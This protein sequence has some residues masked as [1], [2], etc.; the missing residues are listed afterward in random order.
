MRRKGSDF[1]SIRK[2]FSEILEILAQNALPPRRISDYPP[3]EKQGYI[4]IYSISV[5]HDRAQILDMLA[6]CKCCQHYQQKVG[7]NK[8]HK[9]I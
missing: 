4:T 1:F 8:C 9:G 7:H 3:D 5:L 2:S 6:L